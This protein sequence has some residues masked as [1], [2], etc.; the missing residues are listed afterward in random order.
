MIFTL[1][2]ASAGRRNSIMRFEMKKRH[3]PAFP[4]FLF[5]KQSGKCGNFRVRGF[6]I[7]EM[8]ISILLL[9]TGTVATLNMFGIGM[10][11]DAD[12]GKEAIALEL[13]QEEMESIKGTASW[14]AIDSFA[15]PRANMGGEFADF[16]KEVVVA[17]D[18][19]TVQVIV[20]WNNRGAD[21]TVE[22]ATLFTN[23]NY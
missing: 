14:D 19:K 5:P 15:A 20:H 23:Y 1:P 4:L 10:S 12:I 11:V 21:R 22:L 17:G 18:P 6:T 3:V 8:L 16:D 9:V 2:T 13:A 7:L